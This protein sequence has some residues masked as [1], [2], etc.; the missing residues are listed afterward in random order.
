MRLS[1]VLMAAAVGFL[2]SCDAV[3]VSKGV[4]QTKLSEMATADL[5]D[6]VPSTRIARFL[7]GDDDDDDD[8]DEALKGDEDDDKDGEVVDD[9]DDYNGDYDSDDSDDSDDGGDEERGPINVGPAE[10]VVVTAKRLKELSKLDDAAAAKAAAAKATIGKN[11]NKLNPFGLHKGPITNTALVG[12]RV[13]REKQR[14]SED[15]RRLLS[16]IVISDPSKGR[17]G[18]V[19]LI[20]SSR[21]EGKWILPKGGWE[22]DET[23]WASA[24]REAME[25]AGVK[26]KITRPLGKLEFGNTK[27]GKEDQRYRFYGFQMRA[28]KIL[29]KW[30]ENSRQR[31][32]VSY[33]E[34]KR[35]L[36][37]PQLIRM[38]ERAQLANA[39]NAKP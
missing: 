22:I 25:E 37:E 35:L 12:A 11:P 14:Y 5:V 31:R 7:R 30:A 13:G 4:D 19:L 27:P 16:C 1:F 2:A 36:D 10:K 17:A 26:G 39:R 9:D 3:L 8:L 20:S 33:D 6:A 34:A 24:R 29:K 15:G 21:T 23:I 18:E 32:W 28:T 38:V